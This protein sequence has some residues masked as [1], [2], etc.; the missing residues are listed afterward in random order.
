MTTV[1]MKEEP[2]GSALK[3][4][5]II[6]LSLY[7]QQVFSPQMHAG[8]AKVSEQLLYLVA[9][10]FSYEWEKLSHH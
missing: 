5:E 8:I 2:C 3:K 9:T 7:K 4:H 6:S 10:I 1:N